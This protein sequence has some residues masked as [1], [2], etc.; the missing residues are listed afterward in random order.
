MGTRHRDR[1]RGRWWLCICNRGRQER[2]AATEKEE[3][4][5]TFT[6]KKKKGKNF[7]KKNKRPTPANMDREEGA[8]WVSHMEKK[9][10][11]TDRGKY[12]TKKLWARRKG[13]A[14]NVVNKTDRAPTC[15]FSV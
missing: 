14:E 7:Q 8:L 6:K 10:Q 12:T 2:K 13:S 9:I 11:R 15:F 4:A 1:G 3:N 5:I